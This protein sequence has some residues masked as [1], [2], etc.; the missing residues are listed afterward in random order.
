[1]FGGNYAPES[2]AMCE[3]Q[4]LAIADYLPLYSLIGTA[5]GGDGVKT[6]A[7]PN[8]IGCVS[9]GQGTGTGLSPRTVGQAGGSAKV[10]LTAAQIPAHT[11]MVYATTETATLDAVAED[12]LPAAP[13]GTASTLYSIPGSVP[14]V[15]QVFAEAAVSTAGLSAGHENRMPTLALTHI[16]ALNGIFPSR[17]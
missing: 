9:I 12:A 17:S 3:G 16:I 1:M 14:M 4:M 10:V 7:L 6:F 13:A 5:Y 8:L 15:D 2:W 11:H